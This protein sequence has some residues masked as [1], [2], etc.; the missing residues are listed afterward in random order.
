LSWRVRK[1]IK[2]TEDI[3]ITCSSNTI[4]FNF[5]NK[6]I[7][8]NATSPLGRVLKLFKTFQ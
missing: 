2:I 8:I 7:K 4:T 6:Q 1:N 5:Y 3:L